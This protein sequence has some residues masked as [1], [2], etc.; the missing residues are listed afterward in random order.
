MEMAGYDGADAIQTE[1]CSRQSQAWLV[2]ASGRE[3]QGA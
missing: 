1:R 3:P 2:P